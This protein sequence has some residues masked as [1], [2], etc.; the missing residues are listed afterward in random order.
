ML[1]VTLVVFR[2]KVEYAIASGRLKPLLC[3]NCCYFLTNENGFQHSSAR[4]RYVVIN[5][6]NL[7]PFTISKYSF[8]TTVSNDALSLTQDS[9]GVQMGW[10]LWKA[11]GVLG[12]SL[13][14]FDTH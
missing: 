1:R 8:S 9:A 7:W 5:T 11:I 6:V 4:Q 12:I 2:C 14:A 3:I 13:M 10:S